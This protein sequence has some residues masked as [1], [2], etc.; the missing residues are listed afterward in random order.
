[1]SLD[2]K[3]FRVEGCQACG[4]IHKSVTL[5]AETKGRYSFICPVRKIPVYTLAEEG[6]GEKK[7]G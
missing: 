1:M 6:K 7:N 2:G 4:M 3:S 5:K